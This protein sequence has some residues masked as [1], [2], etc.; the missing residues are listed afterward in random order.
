MC[1]HH[2]ICSGR[3]GRAGAKGTCITLFTRQQEHLIRQIENATGN[4]FTRIGAPQPADLVAASG[5]DVTGKMT[6]V[7]EDMIAIFKPLAEAAL[8]E[9]EARGEE[10]ADVL[11]RALAVATGVTS[12]PAVRSLLSCSEG[13]V[14]VA[15][16][17]AHG[18]R[19]QGTSGVWAGL[20][21][22][23]PPALCDEVRGMTLT[24][25]GSGAVFDVPQKLIAA[26]KAA[27]AKPGSKVSIPSVLPELEAKEDAGYGGGY[28]GGGGGFGGRGGFGGGGGRGGFGGRGGG[29]G[30]FGGG[31][32]GFGGGG[33]G[34]FRR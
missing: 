8:S 4:T 26:V 21:A 17:A 10:A 25:D 30:G 32:G 27:A 9:G 24:S 2:L 29:R 19:V 13:Y 28:G 5:R 20:R 11:A 31:R 33:R 34:G 6:S 15:W 7:H 14:T 18:V 3:T 22:E 12:P 16:T 1:V 23:L